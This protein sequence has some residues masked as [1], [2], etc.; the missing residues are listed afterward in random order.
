MKH[1]SFPDIQQFRNVR[2]QVEYM[3]RIVGKDEAGEPIFDPSKPLPV[4]K[5]RGTEKLHGTSSAILTDGVDTWAQSRERIVSIGS[6]NAGFAFFISTLGDSLKKLF[7]SVPTAPVPDPQDN[8]I[9]IFGEWCGGNIQAGVAING[10]P[11]MFVV[12]AVLYKGVWLEDFSS[13]KVPEAQIF[14]INDFATFEIEIDFEKPEGPVEKMEQMVSFVE[15]RSPVGVAFGREGVG[16]GIVWKPVGEL[17]GNTRLWFKT[18]G[19]KHAV[20]KTK[21]VIEVDVQKQASVADFVT[22]TVTEARLKQGVEVLHRNGVTII[23]QTQIGPFL[24]WVVGDIHKEESDVMKASGLEP[25]DVNGAISR[26]AREWL[27]KNE[28]RY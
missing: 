8:I 15:G 12:F 25:K 16:E 14:N 28:L 9:G 20:V 27:M 19:E 26:V 13:V 18:K 7:D 21:R 24:K 11:K 6:D 4:M 23:D 10:L 5:F 17:S 1:I 2:K 3:T 22:R